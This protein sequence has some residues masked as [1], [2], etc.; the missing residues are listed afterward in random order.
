[1]T[2]AVVALAIVSGSCR[3]ASKPTAPSNA[4]VVE[5]VVTEALVPAAAA[6]VVGA[7]IEVTEGPHA[8]ASCVTGTQGTCTLDAGFSG[9][10]TPSIRCTREGFRSATGRFLRVYGVAKAPFTL[11]RDT[12]PDLAGD[13]DITVTAGSSCTGLSP[14]NRVV[15]TSAIL[16][17]PTNPSLVLLEFLVPGKCNYLLG[18][19]RPTGDVEVG[20]DVECDFPRPPGP[21]AIV[22]PPS[23][24]QVTVQGSWTGQ[25]VGGMLTLVQSGSLDFT[26]ADMSE[27]CMAT[28]HQW[29][30]QRK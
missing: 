26:A 9:D 16:S 23:P 17:H 12:T 6:A 30:F 29:R 13:Y 15:S 10:V 7:R 4:Y 5:A 25:A 1:M 22:G 3:D 21:A 18:I 19:I 8:G 24:R 28:D 14:V 2:A 20:H 11:V 27:S